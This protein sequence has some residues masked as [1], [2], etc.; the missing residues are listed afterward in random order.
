LSRDLVKT[1]TSQGSPRV[2]LHSETDLPGAFGSFRNHVR[3]LNATERRGCVLRAPGSYSEGPCLESRP[4]H[5]LSWQVFRGFPY[6]S[7]K[8]LR[9]YL[10][11]VHYCLLPH[12]L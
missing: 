3:L 2:L 6:P 11:I 8:M 5:R 9:Y 10:T 4:L 1:V 7:R 12:L